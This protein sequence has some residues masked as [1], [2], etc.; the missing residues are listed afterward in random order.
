ML[1]DVCLPCKCIAIKEPS[2][3]ELALDFLG[4]PDDLDEATL[5]GAIAN[6][7]LAS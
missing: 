4:F 6:E 3:S 7:D 2:K 5:F 1:S